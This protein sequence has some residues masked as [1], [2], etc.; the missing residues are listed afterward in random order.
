ME[1]PRRTVRAG[2]DRAT[3]AWP[4]GRDVRR[5]F[6]DPW[7]RLNRRLVLLGRLAGWVPLR[8]FR[9]DEVGGRMATPYG[10]RHR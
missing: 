1:R 9:G 2:A 10:T 6:W 5:S 8:S 4:D 7:R 3:N